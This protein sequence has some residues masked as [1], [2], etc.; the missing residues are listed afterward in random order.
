MLQICHQIEQQFCLLFEGSLA[1]IEAPDILPNVELQSRASDS[2]RS[3]Q[4][5]LE[6]A[7]EPL[8]AVRVDVSTD[9]FTLSMIDAL[10]AIPTMEMIVDGECIGVDT[11]LFSDMAADAGIDRYPFQVR[12]NDGEY[13]S[14][15]TV[16]DSQDG[17]LVRTVSTLPGAFVPA[18]VVF[19]STDVGFIDF[20]IS[21]ER[22]WLVCSHTRTYQQSH[23]T[24]PMTFDTGGST[25]ALPGSLPEERLQ[26]QSPFMLRSPV[27]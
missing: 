10:M 25:D 3:F 27:A 8:N 2:S 22:S 23:A 6:A 19:R 24:H 9:I 11:T 26:E 13:S 16:V 4:A 18:F 20:H 14:R 21:S 12:H 17:L 1:V 5:P 15:F 7:P